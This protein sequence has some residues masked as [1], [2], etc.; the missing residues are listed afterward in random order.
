M[1]TQFKN[2]KAKLEKQ[3]RISRLNLTEYADLLANRKE[4]LKK[5]RVQSPPPL[6]PSPPQMT[7][8]IEAEQVSQPHETTTAAH[9]SSI[10]SLQDFFSQ[11]KYDELV[12]KFE[13]EFDSGK[14]LDAVELNLTI[15]CLYILVI[16]LVRKNFFF[17]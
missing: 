7:E 8:N 4:K 13:K 15:H 1:S 12:N 2:L 9:I 5:T 11:K 6:S 16:I 17:F 3:N 14:K 10:T